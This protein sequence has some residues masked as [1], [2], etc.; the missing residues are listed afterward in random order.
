MHFLCL[1]APTQKRGVGYVGKG[2]RLSAVQMC[3]DQGYGR[4]LKE[5][6]RYVYQFEVFPLTVESVRACESILRN[7]RVAYRKEK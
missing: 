4:N 6:A 7:R 1:V 3:I 5:L 2:E